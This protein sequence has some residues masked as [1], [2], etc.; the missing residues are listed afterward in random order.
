MVFSDYVLV[1][2]VVAR[3]KRVEITVEGGKRGN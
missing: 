1:V 2:A 3:Q